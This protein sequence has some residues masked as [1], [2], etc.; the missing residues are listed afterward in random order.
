MTRG[1]M[2][3]DIRYAIVLLSRVMSLPT[4]GHL[5]TWMVHFNETIRTV[6]MSIDWATILSDNLDEQLVVIKTSPHF[7]MKSY[8][9][10]LLAAKTTNYMGLYRKGRRQDENA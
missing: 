8:I 5:Q 3:D 7:Y 1:Y 4:V 6:K 9:L 10:Y 2:K